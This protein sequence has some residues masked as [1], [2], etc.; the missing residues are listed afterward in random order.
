VDEREQPVVNDALVK[1]FAKMID[2]FAYSAQRQ[3]GCVQLEDLKQAGHEGL[4]HAARAFDPRRGVEF[5]TFAEYRIRGAIFD[6]ARQESKARRASRALEVAVDIDAQDPGVDAA[7]RATASF[8][9]RLER[10]VDAALSD[11]TPGGSN[12]AAPDDA[13]EDAEAVRRLEVA[14]AKLSP[15]EREYMHLHLRVGL[16]S[17]EIAGHWGVDKSHVSLARY[18]VGWR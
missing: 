12:A 1:A 2:V 7:E 4:L 17:Q 16:S 6:E 3:Y 18:F 13:Y 9:R 14:L 5:K 10:I 11:F 15:R 8:V